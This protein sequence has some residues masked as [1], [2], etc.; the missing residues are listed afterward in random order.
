[1]PG[2]PEVWTILLVGG[3]SDG[4]V[5]RSSFLGPRLSIPYRTEA[6]GFEHETYEYTLTDPVNWAA[7]AVFKPPEPTKEPT[8]EPT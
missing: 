1:M 5:H 4:K 8:N 6:G 3:H 7:I 2:K